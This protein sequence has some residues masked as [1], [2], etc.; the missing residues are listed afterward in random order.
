MKLS[1]LGE[2][3]SAEVINLSLSGDVG[4]VDLAINVLLWLGCVA[5]GCW[6]SAIFLRKVL[7]CIIKYSHCISSCGYAIL[8]VSMI[9]MILIFC[10]P[11][12]TFELS[13]YC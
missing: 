2:A 9:A 11:V 12:L 8:I 5:D 7:I 6:L 10:L 3:L 13:P 4:N 1:V